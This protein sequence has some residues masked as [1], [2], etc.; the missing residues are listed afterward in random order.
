[1]YNPSIWIFPY[2][3]HS[4]TMR[5]LS[6][7]SELMLLFFSTPGLGFRLKAGS[8]EICEVTGLPRDLTMEVR[9]SDKGPGINAQAWE[10][11]VSQSGKSRSSHSSSCRS[12][13]CCSRRSSQSSSNS[14]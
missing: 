11:Q 6:L 3:G 13:R 9:C 1:M 8:G 4:L 14:S 5:N 10:G 7:S 2:Y 12:S